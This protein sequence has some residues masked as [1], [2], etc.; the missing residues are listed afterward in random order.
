[1]NE[2]GHFIIT[3]H[4]CTKSNNLRLLDFLSRF[5]NYNGHSPVHL[6]VLNEKQKLLD[7]EDE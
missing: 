4:N 5:N 7:Y 3:K 2:T 1:M 6:I